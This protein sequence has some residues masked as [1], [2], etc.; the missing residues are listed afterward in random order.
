MPAFFVC[1]QMIIPAASRS[2]FQ[3]RFC[4]DFEMQ[5]LPHKTDQA[6]NRIFMFI[7]QPLFVNVF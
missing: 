4:Y 7:Y 1:R 3:D 5:Y 6:L 2:I